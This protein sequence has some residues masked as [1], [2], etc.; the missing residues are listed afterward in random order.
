MKRSL[1]L[2]ISGDPRHSARPAEA[3]RIAAGIVPWGQVR[4]QLCFRG[5]A[6]LAL[7]T[8]SEDWQGGDAFARHLPAIAQHSKSIWVQQDSRFLPEVAEPVIGFETVSNAQLARLAAE[9]DCVM[10]F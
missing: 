8:R 9:S 10:R 3:V 5:A 7:D 2:I 1:L 4:V 6:V